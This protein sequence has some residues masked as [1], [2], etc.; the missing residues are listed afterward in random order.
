[1]RIVYARVSTQDQ[2]LEL[3]LDALKKAE[4]EIIFKEKASRKN[5]ERPELEKLFT[6]LRAGDTLVVWKLDGLGR[7]IKDLIGIMTWLSEMDVSFLSRQVNVQ[8]FLRA[9]RSSKEILS[10][11]EPMPDWQMQEPREEKEADHVVLPK[12]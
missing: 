11:K 9:W 2:K 1:M 8:H 7:N 3:Q 10:A 6:K 5:L 12:R 4:Y